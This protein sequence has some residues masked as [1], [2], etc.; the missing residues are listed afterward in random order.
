MRNVMALAEEN[1]EKGQDATCEEVIQKLEALLGTRDHLEDTYE[2][3]K[4][5]W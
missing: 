1:T 3:V 4:T 2:F 5:I